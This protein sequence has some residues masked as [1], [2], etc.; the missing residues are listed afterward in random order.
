[1][2]K[3]IIITG[4]GRSGTTWVQDAIAGANGFRTLFEPLHPIGVPWSQQFGY[5]YVK[6]DEHN[7]P[8]KAFMDKVFSG[9]MKSLWAHYRI[10]PDRFSLLKYRLP[11]VVYN[12][13]KL[14]KH[15][16]IYRPQAATSHG[17]VVKF[18]R[19]NLM[20]G[21]LA[22]TYKHRIL[23]VTRHP[24]AVVASR[25]NM[26]TVDWSAETALSRYLQ[27]QSIVRAMQDEFGVDIARPM[28]PAAIL[29]SVWCIENLLPLRWAEQFGFSV[30]AYETLL[31]E[32]GAEW[33]RI[34]QE[35]ELDKLPDQQALES[36][37]Q[38]VARDMKGR[39]F[40]KTHLGKW[41]TSLNA[42]QFGEIQRVL[43]DFGV[44]IYNINDDM[45]IITSKE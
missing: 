18:I 36:P 1:M 39:K 17:L 10:R 41:R 4:S 3:V 45:P 22:H 21:W 24:A 14:V 43:D 28:T 11:T 7:P 6:A 27:N 32:P 37:S 8:L 38:Q 26:G 16:P 20:L 15:Y 40:G 30:T 44:Q 23:L 9:Q 5:Q 2:S 33:A 29:T 42:E 13:R 34:G 31:A 35:L 12:I 25:I 19:A